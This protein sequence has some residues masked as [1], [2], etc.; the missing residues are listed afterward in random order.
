MHKTSKAALLAGK[1][2]FFF[3]P[4]RLDFGLMLEAGMKMRRIM[5][6]LTSLS[7]WLSR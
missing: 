2:T 7:I 6:L 3:P 5:E 4:M 1:L